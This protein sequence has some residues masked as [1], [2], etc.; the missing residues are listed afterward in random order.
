MRKKALVIW[1]IIIAGLF[2]WTTLRRKN[3][4][5]DKR[6]QVATQSENTIASDQSTSDVDSN[7]NPFP[8]STSSAKQSNP[9]AIM[10]IKDVSISAEQL[11]EKWKS[12][13]PT[14]INALA[15]DTKRL[16]ECLKKDLCGEVASADQPYFD[17]MNTP[18]HALLEHELTTLVFLQEA[19]ELKAN[20]LSSELLMEMLDIENE[21]IQRM[22]L[23]LKLSGDIDDQTYEKLLNKTP[24]LLPQAS[25]NSL[26]ML[27]KESKKSNERREQFLQTAESLLKSSDQSKA[28]EMAKRVQ[29]FGADKIEIERLATA[30]CGLLPQNKKAAQYHL[31]IAGEA[32]G[33]NLSFNCQ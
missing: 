24:S 33:A 1:I 32:V 4:D 27:A 12:D 31:S 20:Q 10:E 18:S 17:K 22:A 30:T 5:E 7:A 9:K 26:S 11:I 13:T 16:T 15:Q 21:S 2:V 23:E 25:A 8:T 3:I 6:A 19:G 28:V 29:Y 14:L